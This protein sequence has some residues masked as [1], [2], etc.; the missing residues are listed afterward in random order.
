MGDPVNYVDPSGHATIYE[1]GWIFDKL[2]RVGKFYVNRSSG[3]YGG[4]YNL[5]VNGVFA[6]ANRTWNR[7]IALTAAALVYHGLNGDLC[8]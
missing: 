3:C 8:Q 1:I 5:I 6:A 2:L 4:E 7:T